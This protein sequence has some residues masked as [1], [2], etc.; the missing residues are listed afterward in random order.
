MSHLT[1]N[2]I[3]SVHILEQMAQASVVD[4]N[5]HVITAESS[6]SIENEALLKLNSDLLEIHKKHGCTQGAA[7]EANAAP[8][9][10]ERLN[11][12]SHVAADSGFWRWL[13]LGPLIEVV[14]ARNDQLRSEHIGLGSPW[15]CLLSRLWYR[16]DIAIDLRSPDQY[17]LVRY[18]DLDFWRSHLLRADYS[19]CRELIRALIRF[20]YPSGSEGKPRLKPSGDSEDGIRQLSK[21]IK[22]RQAT[23]AFELLTEESCSMM[24][25]ELSGGLH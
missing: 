16:A 7:F 20:Q 11:L 1:L 9:L 17:E 25:E 8:L 23:V 2:P 10:H 18:G 5:N 21:R 22:L 3:D 19:A 13:S 14:F 15:D 12:I 6:W 24:L 4:I